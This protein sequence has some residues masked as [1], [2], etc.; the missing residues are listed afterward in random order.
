MNTIL[1][2]VILLCLVS[3][4]VTIMSLIIGY[5]HAKPILKQTVL[6]LVNCDFCFLYITAVVLSCFNNALEN[7]DYEGSQMFPLLTAWGQQ[8]V[9]LVASM[10]LSFGIILRYVQIYQ[11]KM[12]M[13][14]DELVRNVLRL[15]AF[16][17]SLTSCFALAFGVNKIPC[18]ITKFLEP[19]CSESSWILIN[20]V[21]AFSG[22]IAMP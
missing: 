15:F 17:L 12:L 7:L 14:D 9:S 20:F 21:V 8:I 11:N 6:D 16:I 1:Y 4:H 18:N 19:S 22:K 5:I 2:L 10:Y 3:S 13:F